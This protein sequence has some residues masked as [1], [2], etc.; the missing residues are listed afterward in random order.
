MRPEVQLCNSVR[1]HCKVHLG[2]LWPGRPRMRTG[3]R[4]RCASD[5]ARSW[6]AELVP[7]GEEK[8]LARGQVAGARDVRSRPRSL[9]PRCA[10]PGP[11]CSRGEPS[12]LTVRR[13][14]SPGSALLWRPTSSAH[15]RPKRTAICRA[16]ASV[17]PSL[18]RLL[19]RWYGS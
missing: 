1:R 16:D 4:R 13:P 12:S 17:T 3:G 6:R 14:W 19:V 2:R 18:C 8:L 9:R 5:M 11:R 10:W 7:A 15:R